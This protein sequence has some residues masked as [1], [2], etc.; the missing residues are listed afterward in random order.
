MRRYALRDDQWGRMKKSFFPAAKVMWAALQPTIDCSS[1]PFSTAT[2]LVFLGVI[3][4]NVS[5]IGKSFINASAD[6]RRVAFLSV[7]STC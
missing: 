7:S 2:E 6:G 1:K 3:C 4:R 5:V